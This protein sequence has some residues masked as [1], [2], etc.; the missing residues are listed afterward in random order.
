M[1]NVF[2][3]MTKNAQSVKIIGFCKQ[4]YNF[5]LDSC[6]QEDSRKENKEKKLFVNSK[7]RILL[8]SL[9]ASNVIAIYS[10]L[11]YSL[12]STIVNNAGF[13]E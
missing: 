13:L 4:K 10:S 6:K 3:R 2:R 11:L 1:E 12:K 9:K 8:N 5:R 7:N